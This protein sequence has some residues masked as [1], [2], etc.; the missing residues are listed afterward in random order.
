M[1]NSYRI[2]GVGGTDDGLLASVPLVPNDLLACWDHFQE[3]LTEDHDVVDGGLVWTIYPDKTIFENR[4][5][6]LIVQTSLARL[7]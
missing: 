6:K 1:S 5:S 4:E 3:L 7:M 2:M